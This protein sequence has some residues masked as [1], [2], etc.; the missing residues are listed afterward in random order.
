LWAVCWPVA[1]RHPV[2][3]TQF[4]GAANDKLFKFAFAVMVTYQLS[5][6]WLPPALSYGNIVVFRSM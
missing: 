4:P 1:P 6:S 5:V 2:F 3:W